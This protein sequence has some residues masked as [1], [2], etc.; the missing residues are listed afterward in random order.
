M[1]AIPLVPNMSAVAL[2]AL[3]AQPFY[4]SNEPLLANTLLVLLTVVCA[5]V[6]LVKWTVLS[7]LSAL[8]LGF[9]S[10]A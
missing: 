4:M 5:M 6:G 9:A 3:L 8:T 10:L 2:F 1:H 7:P